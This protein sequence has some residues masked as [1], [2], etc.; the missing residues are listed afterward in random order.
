MQNMV[1]GD[2]G[3]FRTKNGAPVD[4]DPNVMLTSCGALEASNVNVIDS[5]VNMI[6]L[7]RQFDMHMT[8]LKTAETNPEEPVALNR[9]LQHKLSGCARS[10]RRSGGEVSR[11]RRCGR[12]STGPGTG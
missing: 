5:M 9:S 2:D 4:A 7:S 12:C 8:M 3:L 6:N 11:N 10:P 1:R